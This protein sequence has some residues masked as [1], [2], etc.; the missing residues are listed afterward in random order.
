MERIQNLKTTAW[1]DEDVK[2]LE[3]FI[4]GLNDL[5]RIKKENE[6]LKYENNAMKELLQEIKAIG[7]AVYAFQNKF[8]KGYETKLLPEG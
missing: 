1:S 7:E 2:K 8:I 6:N 3:E 5:E 4:A